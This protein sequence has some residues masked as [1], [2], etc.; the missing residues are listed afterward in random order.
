M[1]IEKSHIE[2][3]AEVIEQ[4]LIKSPDTD[5]LD[6]VYELLRNATKENNILDLDQKYLCSSAM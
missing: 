2:I 3:D 4:V 1:E 6:E 5:I